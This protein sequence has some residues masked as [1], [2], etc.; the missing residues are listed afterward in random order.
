LPAHPARIG[1]GRQVERFVEKPDLPTACAFLADERYL[2][3]SGMFLFRAAAY[4]RELGALEPDLLAACE[5]AVAHGY[6]DLDF[7]A[8]SRPPLPAAAAFRSTM[9]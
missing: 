2:W 6:R 9:P 8:W 1:H 3:N 5:Q 7:A 4:L